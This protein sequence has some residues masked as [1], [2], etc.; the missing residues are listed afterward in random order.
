MTEMVRILLVED[1]PLTSKDLQEIMEDANCVAFPALS[2]LEALNIFRSQEID[3]AF[4]DITLEG[5]PFNGIQLA[6][7]LLKVKSDLLLVFVTAHSERSTAQKAMSLNPAQYLIKP[8]NEKQVILELEKL[9]LH[10][11]KRRAE[12]DE[13]R[14]LR[15]SSFIFLP[16]KNA[17][18]RIQKNDIVFVKADGSYVKVYFTNSTSK[19]FSIKFGDFLRVLK[20]EE[21]AQ[22]HRSYIINI[23]HLE[24][25]DAGSVYISGI[26]EALPLSSTFKAELER[27]L[28][29]LKTKF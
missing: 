3:A 20:D 19:T 23:Q 4:I 12:K 24:K 2:Y 14:H 28:P 26:K 29:I 1:N 7:E 25:Y 8:Y 27:K 9:R 22:I 10:I 11:F 13:I 5:S 17:R 15:D 6:E 21:F 18:V 16:D